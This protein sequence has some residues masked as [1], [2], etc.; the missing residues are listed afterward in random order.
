VKVSLNEQGIY[1]PKY[2]FISWESIQWYRIDYFSSKSGTKRV[3]LKVTGGKAVILAEEGEG[4][5]CIEAEIKQKLHLHNPLAKDFKELMTSKI[6][7]SILILIFIT[8]HLT[9]CILTNYEKKYI[10]IFTPVLLITIGAIL[11]EH[12]NI[13]GEDRKV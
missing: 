12:I 10:F 9:I 11:M 4:L 5:D 3:V 6:R 1:L 2:N 8:I 13:S 7:A